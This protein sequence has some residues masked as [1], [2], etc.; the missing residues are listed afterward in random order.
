MP[1]AEFQHSWSTNFKQIF[2]NG[3]IGE[4]I[5]QIDNGEQEKEASEKKKN[6]PQN[7]TESNDF[8]SNNAL[9]YMH[10]IFASNQTQMVV[11]D[12]AGYFRFG[13]FV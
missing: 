8:M 12:A 7:E 13:F 2:F 1:E 4:R 10:T 6:E 11:L 9:V 5:K 3:I